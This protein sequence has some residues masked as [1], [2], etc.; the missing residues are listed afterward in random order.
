MA[1]AVGVEGVLRL[2]ARIKYYLNLLCFVSGKHL[3]ISV[4]K[5][6]AWLF[7]VA[8]ETQYIYMHLYVVLYKLTWWRYLRFT[9]FVFKFPKARKNMKIS[10]IN[11]FFFCKC[12]HNLFTN[13][14]YILMQAVF[15][16]H[17]KKSKDYFYELQLF[18]WSS[19]FHF[20]NQ[21]AQYIY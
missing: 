17:T 10:K 13:T 1:F 11:F 15:S 14:Y 7:Q 5:N 6:R 16:I 21:T 12:S 2:S 19:Y 18:I 20:L 3:I 4:S 8:S 9:L